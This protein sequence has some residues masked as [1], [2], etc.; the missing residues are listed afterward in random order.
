M[1]CIVVKAKGK[2]CFGEMGLLVSAKE[3]SGRHTVVKVLTGEGVKDWYLPKVE[4]VK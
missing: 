4:V 1:N 2:Y 3:N